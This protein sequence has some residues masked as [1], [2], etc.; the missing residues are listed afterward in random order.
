MRDGLRL[1]WVVVATARRGSRFLLESGEVRRCSVNV[2]GGVVFG[3]L[4]ACGKFIAEI[5]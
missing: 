5:D 4:R 2:L 1:E 3:S